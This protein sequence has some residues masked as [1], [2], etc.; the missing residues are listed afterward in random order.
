MITKEVIKAEIDKIQDQYLTTLYRIIKAFE[1]IPASH[2]DQ[3]IQNSE[4][5]K[6]ENE[7]RKEWLSFIRSTYG[8]LSDDPIERGDQ[9]EFEI[10]ETI[11]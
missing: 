8:S 3:D 9:G 10:R 2:R 11:H 1:D 5:P 7:E 4:M 6:D